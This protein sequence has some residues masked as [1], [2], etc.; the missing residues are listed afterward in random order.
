[1]CKLLGPPNETFCP[2]VH[3]LHIIFQAGYQ[4]GLMLYLTVLGNLTVLAEVKASKDQI[5]VKKCVL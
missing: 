5:T 2:F 4:G 1:M 3:S